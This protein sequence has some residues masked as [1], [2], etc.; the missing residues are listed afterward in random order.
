MEH[1]HTHAPTHTHTR[2]HMHTNIHIRAHI[3][4]FLEY[5]RGL[6]TKVLDSGLEVSEFELQSRYYVHLIPLDKVW[7]LL[8]SSTR[9]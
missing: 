8:S 9:G 1:K 2:T 5:L 6:M 4:T 3:H 7:N